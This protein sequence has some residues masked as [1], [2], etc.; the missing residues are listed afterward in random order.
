MTIRLEEGLKLTAD[1]TTLNYISMVLHESEEY[2]RSSGYV[3]LANQRQE[4]S[5][6]I[7]STLK[8]NGFYGE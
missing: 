2:L 3:G 6:K 8:K 1:E 4:C 5:D 7:Y